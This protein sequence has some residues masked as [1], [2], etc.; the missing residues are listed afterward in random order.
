MAEMILKQ[1]EGDRF[2][3]PSRGGY[4]G[5]DI[6]A[7]L[8]FLDHPL[9]AAHLSLDAA[10]PPNVCGLVVRVAVQRALRVALY[11]ISYPAMFIGYLGKVF[12]S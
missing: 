5:E 8:L 10:Q 1:P 3:G 2:Q 11:D 6:D 4:L 12:S 9:Q 7:V